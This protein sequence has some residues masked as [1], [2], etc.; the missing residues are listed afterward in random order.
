MTSTK[1][2]EIDT[3][4]EKPELKKLHELIQNDPSILD[5][6]NSD[7]D[8]ETESDDYISTKEVA[9]QKLEES[10]R[11]LKLDLN[12]EKLKTIELEEKLAKEIAKNKIH[13]TN[14]NYTKEC[15]QFLNSNYDF[16]SN[17][18]LSNIMDY[19]KEVIDM[20]RQ[21]FKI[22]REYNKI[23]QYN[24]IELILKN[25]YDILVTLK[26]EEIKTM[27]N[28]TNGTLKKFKY[29]YNIIYF[30]IMIN[31]LMFAYIFLIK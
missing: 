7:S 25:N 23:K 28:K 27:Y 10:I 12:N 5:T 17:I 2:N 11:Y 4:T 20:A 29:T 3:F 22:E 18:S 8:S 26:F 16:N 19:N 6:N 21:F 13:E 1:E 31:F 30:L 9:N 24:N 15:L 14:I